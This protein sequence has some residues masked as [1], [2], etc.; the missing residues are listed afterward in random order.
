MKAS[1]TIRQST[2]LCIIIV[3]AA[4]G[5]AAKPFTPPQARE[6]PPGPG[7]F[8]KDVDGVVIYRSDQ[9]AGVPGRMGKDAPAT[10]ETSGKPAKASVTE[11][12]PSDYEEFEAYQKWLQ[13]KKSAAGTPEY[14]QFQHWR[15][16]RQYQEWKN[17]E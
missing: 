16:W 1:T 9:G 4:W 10:A 3:L 7:V 12:A 14:E 8:T 2:L 13:W 6:I 5:C 15:Q 17:R 11:P